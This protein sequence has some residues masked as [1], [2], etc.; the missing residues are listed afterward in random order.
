MVSK[1]NDTFTDTN[2]VELD[3]HAPELGGGYGF[4]F[5]AEANVTIE[6][7]RALTNV[8]GSNFA[9]YE[10]LSLS[11]RDPIVK[12]RFQ[13]LGDPSSL[14]RFSIDLRLGG[15]GR[16]SFTPQSNGLMLVVAFGPGGEFFEVDQVVPSLS[17]NEVHDLRIRM[18]GSEFEVWIDEVSV[19]RSRI[20]ISF[21][22]SG[23]QILIRRNTTG[24]TALDSLSIEEVPAMTI[25]IKNGQMNTH[26][27]GIIELL[28]AFK[29][30]RGLCAG[31]AI[32]YEIGQIGLY[33]AVAG[34]LTEQTIFGDLTVADFQ[35]Y[36][37]IS[38]DKEAVGEDCAGKVQF[39]TDPDGV[40]VVIID[41]QVWTMG[42]PGTTNNVIGMYVAIQEVGGSAPKL[43]GTLAFDPPAPMIAAGDQV[44]ASGYMEIDGAMVE[45]AA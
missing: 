32:L 35:D 14:T 21:P 3:D 34:T 26:R 42:T 40:P 37:P 12:C 18:N 8:A 29:N 45:E 6:S 23:G 43:L 28:D 38:I 5:G 13:F 15:G 11:V 20:P 30:G 39:G 10:L 36:A 31:D 7:N 44:K 17:D 4:L 33:T 27:Q 24:Q 2:G 16:V 22:G 25:S 19:I 9:S 1:W 41:Q